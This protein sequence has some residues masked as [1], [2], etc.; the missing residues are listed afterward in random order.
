MGLILLGL[1]LACSTIFWDLTML[2]VYSL[3]FVT[4][5]YGLTAQQL[6]FSKIDQAYISD[7]KIDQAYISDHEIKTT[8][9]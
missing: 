4:Y 8:Q 3:F 1:E 2:S 5:Y 7:H 6:W 9:D